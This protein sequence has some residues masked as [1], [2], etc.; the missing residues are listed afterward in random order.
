[1]KSFINDKF[2]IAASS[3]RSLS[4]RITRL[5]AVLSPLRGNRNTTCRVAGN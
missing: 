4:S 1:M 2:A 3:S 5:G